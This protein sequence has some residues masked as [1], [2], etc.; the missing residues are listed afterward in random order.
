M[1]DADE[2]RMIGLPYGE[3]KT[4]TIGPMLS[5][6][7]LIPE[8]YGRT[9]GQ[10]DRGTDLLH[11]Y[12]AS[13]CW[14]AKKKSVVY[15]QLCSHENTSSKLRRCL[16]GL[17]VERRVVCSIKAP[18]GECLWGGLYKALDWELWQHEPISLWCRYTWIILF[19]MS[20]SFSRGLLCW[21]FTVQ[22]TFAQSI[23]FY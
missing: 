22:P 8:R 4:M 17:N 21:N 13:V 7:H 19:E 16:C 11:Q 6:F 15:F 1:F 12:R 10:T 9:D 18:S 3:K 23:Q 14:R 2:Y 20:F 5:R